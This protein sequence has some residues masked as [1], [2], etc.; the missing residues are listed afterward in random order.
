MRQHLSYWLFF[1]DIMSNQ[2]QK[3]KVYEIFRSLNSEQIAVSLFAIILGFIG[4]AATDIVEGMIGQVGI[5]L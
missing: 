4:I 1:K 5:V 3:R 2:D